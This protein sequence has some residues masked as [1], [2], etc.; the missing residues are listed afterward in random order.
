MGAGDPIQENDTVPWPGHISILDCSLP[1]SA[2]V[3]EADDV[4]SESEEY[5]LKGM[6]IWEFFFRG[7]YFG[8]WFPSLLCT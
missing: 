1:G 4:L 7:T 2:P 6:V 5:T 8:I 3:S